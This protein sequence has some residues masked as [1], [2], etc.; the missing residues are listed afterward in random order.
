MRW[1]VFAALGCS[2]EQ[3]PEAAKSPPKAPV[4][5]RSS[6]A[7]PSAGRR[8]PD[9]LTVS[10]YGTDPANPCA[11]CSQCRVTEVRASSVREPAGGERFEA[12]HLVDENPSS[13]WCDVGT[14][15]RS[16]VTFGIP[17]GCR[18]HGLE[19]VSGHVGDRV[20]L[21]DNGRAAEITLSAG[22]LQG[23]AEIDDP[24]GLGLNVKQLID[25]PAVVYAGWTAYE[26]DELTVTIRE[27]HRGGLHGGVCLSE[28]RP[29][30]TRP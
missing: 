17:R 16:S 29:L 6:R 18:L 24:V 15:D 20:R 21:A 13:A 14:R 2:N 22:R 5:A 1:F 25:K 30:L 4:M 11:D 8:G 19:I 9:A 23:E 10:S 3:L 7:S 26:I 12:R 28:L 27:I